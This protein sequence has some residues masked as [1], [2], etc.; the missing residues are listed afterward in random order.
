MILN[1]Q[2]IK[3]NK[4]IFKTHELTNG[5]AKLCMAFNIKKEHTKY[6]LCSWKGMWIENSTI[7]NTECIKIV[8]CTRIGIESVGSEWASKNLRYYIFGNSSVSKRDKKAEDKL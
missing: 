6:S 1:R 4:K 3:K 5:P 8:K 2:Q 7:E